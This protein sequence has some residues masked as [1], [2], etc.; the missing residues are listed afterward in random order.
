MV[1]TGNGEYHLLNNR[2]Q[3]AICHQSSVLFHYPRFDALVIEAITY[4]SSILPYIL[5][6]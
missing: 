6:P 4:I 1:S 2:Y 3:L 5:A